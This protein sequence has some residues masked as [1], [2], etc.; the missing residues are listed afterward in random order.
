MP[1]LLTDMG[2]FARNENVNLGATVFVRGTVESRTPNRLQGVYI[3]TIPQVY[4]ANRCV[5]GDSGARARDRARRGERHRQTQRRAGLGAAV[6]GHGGAPAAS[7]L[8]G[9]MME[10]RV[11]DWEETALLLQNCTV[12]PTRAGN[13]VEAASQHPGRSLW[14][15]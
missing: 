1:R 3:D 14:T 9:Q 15:F 13:L 2:G 8:R 6:R 11:M 7:L 5:C 10:L 4:S 12:I